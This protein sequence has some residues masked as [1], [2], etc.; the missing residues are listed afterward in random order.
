MTVA[1]IVKGY[2]RLSETFIAQ[3]ILG[4]EER[5]VAQRIISLRHPTD[6]TRHAM[7]E[8]IAA[9]VH[10][11]P[12][13]VHEEP[14]R[15]WR[16]WR[17]ARRLPGYRAA[18]A[19]WLRDW[20]RDPTLNRARRFAQAAVL[21]AELPDDVTRF[22]VHFLHTPA[23]VA[24]YASLM[25]GL[26]WSCSAHAKDIWTTPQWET[27]EKLAACEWL[28][29]CTA[30]GA[31]HLASLTPQP[32]RVTLVYHGLDLGR[33]PPPPERGAHDGSDPARPVVIAS[34]GRA[35]EKKGYDV[36]LAA[37][38]LLPPELHWRFVHIGG[39]KL[40][41]RLK[42]AAADL[43]AVF[44]GA[45]PQ[46]RVVEELRQAD[47]F[48]L[49]CRIAP[50]GDRDGLPNVLMEAASQGLPAVSTRVSAV[51]EFVSPGETGL[52]VEP[53]DPQALAAALATL[54]RNPA[55][56]AAMGRAA[57]ARVRTAFS[58]EAGIDRLA[59]RFGPAPCALRS[60][61]R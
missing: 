28:V 15:V 4:L 47:L 13:Y 53:E 60:M 42:Q 25:T 10:Y 6:P 61:R 21:V 43:P 56:R 38:R 31:E 16:G 11:L 8:Q 51:P 26:P 57:C 29:T 24:R 44:L 52:L 2:P 1:V 39:G 22:H 37:L 34:V 49:A 5:G 30:A 58:F 3:E 46:D 59:A 17:L 7:H 27:R 48:A 12:E 45:Q 54:I 35:V 40:A 20:R 23:S 41:G 50:D 55:E 18:R 14:R 33:F 36:L 19:V 9:P 32:E